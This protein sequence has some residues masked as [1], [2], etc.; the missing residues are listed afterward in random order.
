MCRACS[1]PSLMITLPTSTAPGFA[2]VGRCLD[3]IRGGEGWLWSVPGR[4]EHPGALIP[5]RIPSQKELQ[6]H[7]RP[8]ASE[9]QWCRN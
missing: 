5:T 2:G 6:K 8:A 9:A 4:R 7:F 3:G 1:P